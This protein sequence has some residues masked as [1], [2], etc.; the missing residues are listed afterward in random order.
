MKI[1]KALIFYPML[2]LRGIFLTIGSIASR[3]LLII[4]I[5]VLLF[6]QSSQ[7][8]EW[9]AYIL[10]AASFGFF[11]LNHFYDLILLK[12]NPTDCELYLEQ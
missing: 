1:L 9:V 12:L 7:H 5:A 4:A 2:W 11:L 10:F 3:L 8:N 6:T